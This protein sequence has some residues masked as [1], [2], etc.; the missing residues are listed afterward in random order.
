MKDD[1]KINWVEGI[2]FDGDKGEIRIMDQRFCL[3]TSF[4]FRSF[5]DGIAKVIGEGGSDAVLY[6]AGKLHTEF[7]VKG[8][9][10]KS[11]MARVAKRFGW[12]QVKIMEKL[13]KVL[14]QYGFGVT[15]IEKIDLKKES[16]LLM[17]NS[18][19]ATCYKTKRK[20][21]VCSYISGLIAGAMTVVTG[22]PFE[23]QET[24]CIAKGDKHC[25]FL[26]KREK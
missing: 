2:K 17:D 22:K 26:I 16:M 1:E 5:R 19:I 23:V 13:T 12:G 3:H 11:T 25:R 10:E 21:P 14:N 20:K 24:H 9:L 18:C 8:I 4:A 15:S 7:F 6:N